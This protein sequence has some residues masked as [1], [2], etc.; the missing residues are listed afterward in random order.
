MGLKMVTLHL[1]TEYIKILDDLVAQGW[2]SSRSSAIRTAVRDLLRTETT[3]K[4]PVPKRLL[5]EIERER[6]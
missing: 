1:P 4:C 3:W 2:Y 6:G 5:A